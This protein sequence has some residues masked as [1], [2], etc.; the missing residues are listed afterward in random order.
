MNSRAKA[1][2]AAATLAL[3][4]SPQPGV[5]GE[6]WDFTLGIY[7][8]FPDLTG[9]SNLPT[10]GEGDFRIDIGTILDNLEF[11]LQG[12]F[13]ARHG[14]VGIFTDVIY[15][16]VGNSKTGYSDGTIGGT[17]IPSDAEATVKLDVESLLWTTSAYY[18]L[19]DEAGSSLDV[20]FGVR[21][22]DLQQTLSW[23]LEGNASVEPFPGRNGSR[24]ISADYFDGIVGLRGH[25]ALGSGG[26][27]FVPY[28]A[29]IGTGDSDLTWQAAAGI[30][31]AFSRGELMAGWRYLSYDL[32]TGSRIED[33]EFSGPQ[34]GG[35][36]R[37]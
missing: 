33:I 28:Y 15:L 34:V 3:A 32:P 37:W 9:T 35:T 12:N 25:A 22:A 24:E 13:D 18:R 36:F 30:G 23:T 29:D 19:F 6:E 4:L 11:T 31:Y 27:W 17:P 20:M 5:A 7:G 10:G 26:K 14:R 1:L 16:D 8:Y 2:T 21:Y